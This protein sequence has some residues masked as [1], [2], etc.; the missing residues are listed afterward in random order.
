MKFIDLLNEEILYEEMSNL[1]NKETGLPMV[2]WLQP[3]TRR[4]QHWAR[5]K[6]S[7]KYGDKVSEDL[8][9][10]TI[11]NEPQVVGDTGD[12]KTN[13]IKKVIEFVKI[14]K[15]LLL[16]FWNDEIAVSDLI[17]GIKKV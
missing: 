3:K 6:V 16:D 5:I 12:I 10:I 4:E 11:E 8:F 2:V 17:N 15:D 9:T 1:R 13:D 14:N 7:K